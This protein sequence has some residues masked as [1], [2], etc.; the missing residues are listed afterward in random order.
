MDCDP[1]VRTTALDHT[2]SLLGALVAVFIVYVQRSYRIIRVMGG[3]DQANDGHRE[4]W[5]SCVT[6]DTEC[7]PPV[8]MRSPM[9]GEQCIGR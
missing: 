4:E 6:V 3:D 8:P 7:C 2:A 1:Q 5:S 9:A